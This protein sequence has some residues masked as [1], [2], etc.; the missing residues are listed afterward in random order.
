MI[1]RLLV[2]CVVFTG[3]VVVRRRQRGPELTH[4]VPAHLA[5]FDPG[6]W[7][8]GSEYQR[9][10]AWFDARCLWADANLPDGLE[11]LPDW[12]GSVPDQPWGEVEL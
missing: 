3:A 10:A 12:D 8:G 6:L 2:A 9:Y 7:P 4:G 1:C 5:D 11:G